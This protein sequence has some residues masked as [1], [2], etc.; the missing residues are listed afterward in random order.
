MYFWYS[1][2][3]WLRYRDGTVR[4]LIEWSSSCRVCALICIRIFNFGFAAGSLAD[5][6]AAGFSAGAGAGATDGAGLA[7]G[8]GAVASGAAL[9]S[10][11]NGPACRHMTMAAAAK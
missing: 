1:F 9:S 5:L 7:A 6:S 8:A 11:N 3:T 4:V 10:A 2:G